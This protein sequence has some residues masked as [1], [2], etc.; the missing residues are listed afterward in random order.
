MPKQKKLLNSPF[1]LRDGAVVLRPFTRRDLL[2][3]EYLRWMNDPRVTRTIGRFDYLFPVSRAKLIEYFGSIDTDSTIFLGIHAPTK[4]RRRRVLV[5][6]LKI[7]DIDQLARRAA[8]GIMVGD[9]KVWG[10][11]IASTAISMACRYVFGEL[12][13]QKIV[14]GYLATNEGMR[15]AFK[16][17]DFE[18]EGV[19]RE[20]FFVAGQLV[21]HV[22]VSK[23]RDQ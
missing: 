21:D 22:L 11:G 17:N 3:A 7:Y 20:Q 15:R 1:F 2:S 5:G 4:V 23:F 18:I 14:A 12:G 8:L 13:F 10:R 16:K 19:L 9:T 6:T